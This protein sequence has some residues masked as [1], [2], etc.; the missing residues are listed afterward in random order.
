[1]SFDLDRLEVTGN[2][3][4]VLDGV[5][6]FA[7]SESGSLAY[8]PVTA[9]GANNRTLVLVDR[10]GREEALPARPLPYYIPRFSP[11][12][13]RLAIDVT[14]DQNRDIWIYD[15]KRQKLTR[16][17]FHP[18]GDT[19][20]VWTPDGQHLIFGADRDRL[21]KLHRQAADG[22]GQ[23][24]LLTN[25][26]YQQIPYSISPNGK[27]VVILEG[28]SGGGIDVSV[29]S[30]DG[31]PTSKPLFRTPF[32]EINPALSPDGRWLA[33][34]SNE[35][36]RSEIYVR[37]FPDV[38]SGK[39][40]VSVGSGDWPAWAPDGRELYYR[41]GPAMV[42][43]PIETEP[44]FSPGTP[45]V[46]FEGRYYSNVGRT[47][48]VS[49]DGRHFLMIKDNPDAAPTPL[50]VVLNWTEALKERMREADSATDRGS[51]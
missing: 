1:V 19:Y 41:L 10:Q 39:Y 46:L 12:G 3:L 27:A 20:P 32:T 30:L 18:E 47:Y 48:D 15:L 14:V 26:P 2:P 35:S 45:E 5:R 50:R 13:T 7:L 29:L 38:D 4:K 51:P 25:S 49:P 16:L 23:P 44:S 28:D 42:A 22:V 43:V 37:P 9:E 34:S 24:E 21:R 8:I 33:Y 31:E 36:G 6:S 17:T 11:D 40:Q